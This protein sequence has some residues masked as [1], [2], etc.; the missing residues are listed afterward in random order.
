MVPMTQ[1]TSKPSTSQPVLVDTP[2]ALTAMAAH[3]STQNAFALDTESNSFYVYYP[4]VC[5]IQ[6]TTF[7]DAHNPATGD[8]VDYLVDPLTLTNLEELGALTA[9][10][11]IQVIMHAAENDILQLQRDF[12]FT[13]PNVFD[14]QLAARILGWEHVGLGSMLEERFGVVS[15]KRMQR[16]DWAVRPLTQDQI[17]YAQMDTH[18]LLALRD[19]LLEALSDAG[20][21]EEFEESIALLQQFDTI[22]RSPNDRSFWQ[23]KLTRSIDLAHTGVLETLWN[24]REREAQ[25]T[26]RPPFKIMGDE[27]LVD[28]AT[29]RPT[30]VDQL[31]NIARLSRQQANR[32]GTTVLRLVREGAER[33]LPPLPRPTVRPELL[34]SQ[35]DQGRFEKLRRWRTETARARGVSPEIVFNN[36]TLLA[37]VQRHPATEADLLAIPGIGPWKA[38]AYGEAVF[39]LLNGN[40]DGR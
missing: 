5:L 32:Y 31:K 8:V 38:S 30:S 1:S 6:I 36:D 18:Y 2:Q 16:T 26:N 24:W 9:R 7:A 19:Q 20:R 25:R 40:D 23:M 34:L 27:S 12:G 29:T 14:T 35:E 39:G 17:V 11:D 10:G 33:P 28:L 13:F 4:K 3:L 37:I 22:E 15:D 21:L